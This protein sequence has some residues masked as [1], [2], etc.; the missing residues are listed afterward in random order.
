[1]IAQ[2]DDLFSAEARRF[3]AFIRVECGLAPSTIEA[4]SADLADLFENLRESGVGAPRDVMHADLIGYIASLRAERG[5][6][7][8]TVAR[9]LA[10]MKVFFRWLHNRGGIESNPAGDLDQPARW[11]RLPGVLSPRQARQLIE[12]VAGSPGDGLGLHLR[13]RALLETLYACGLRASEVAALTLESLHRTLGV[14]L[15]DGKGGKQRLCPIGAPAM[16]AID[17]YLAE[18][19]PGLARAHCEDRGRLFI[20]RTGRPLE[21]V[22]VW[23]IVKRRA[24]AAGVPGVYPHMLRHSFATH[25]LAG[26]ADLRVVQELLGHADI[27]T[28]QIYT[29]VD[30]TQIK[31]VH[32]AHHPRP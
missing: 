15:I 8:A 17:E 24:L 22:A 23:Q 28:T 25:L 31:A 4:Y 30:T 1:M 19:R 6:A 26:G 14:A 21:R 13:D 2:S 5:Y 10:T 29:H 3:T 18:C 20:S 11:R 7:G 9:R 32:R 12:S 16:R 27:T